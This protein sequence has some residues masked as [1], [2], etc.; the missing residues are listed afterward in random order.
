MS[1]PHLRYCKLICRR[2]RVNDVITKDRI[3]NPHVAFMITD[4]SLKAEF[5]SC[6]CGLNKEKRFLKV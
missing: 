3:R 1:K 5:Q 6:R 2:L 4:E